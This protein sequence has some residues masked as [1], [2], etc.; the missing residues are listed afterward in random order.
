MQALEGIG[1]RVR[2][3][4]LLSLIA[5]TGA[6]AQAAPS[7]GDA[8]TDDNDDVPTVVVR[9]DDDPLSQSDRKLAALIKGLPGADH[10]VAAKKSIGEKIG[11]YYDAHRSPNDLSPDSQQRLV[12]EVNGDPDRPNLP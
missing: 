9:P 11:D 12:R 2:I 6:Y 4:A 3:S 8:V 5:T 7:P 1:R 10:P